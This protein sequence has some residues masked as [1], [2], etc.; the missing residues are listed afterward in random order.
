M[1]LLCHS[2][3]HYLLHATFDVRIFHFS[4]HTL[5]PS[6]SD[7]SSHIFAFCALSLSAPSRHPA[8]SMK[9]S[10]HIF[11]TP[12]SVANFRAVMPLNT[13]CYSILCPLSVSTNVMPNES[14]LRQRGRGQ[15]AS[16]IETK[17]HLRNGGA[18]GPFYHI[19]CHHI[20]YSAKHQKRQQYAAHIICLH[21]YV[22]VA[23]P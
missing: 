9:L 7:R 18:F 17:C 15:A 21:L 14:H 10:A 5:T 8:H 20:Q 11:S 1:P 16:R 6:A 12:F 4:P 13:I 22:G 2:H 3:P 19:S 23:V